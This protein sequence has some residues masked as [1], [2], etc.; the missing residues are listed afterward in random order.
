MNTKLTNIQKLIDSFTKEVVH[1]AFEQGEVYLFRFSWLA[2]AVVGN[3]GTPSYKEFLVGG[4]DKTTLGMRHVHVF[5][6]N[7]IT[8]GV[9]LSREASTRTV[10]GKWLKGFDIIYQDDDAILNEDV[11]TTVAIYKDC[12]R[13]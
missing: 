7:R 5:D 4:Y 12:V 1:E 3:P 11:K 10:D 13:M 9:S 6:Y 8:K 2:K